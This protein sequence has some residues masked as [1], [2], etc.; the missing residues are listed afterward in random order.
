MRPDDG[1]FSVSVQHELL[2]RVSVDVSYNRRWFENFFVDDNQLVGP[3]GLQPVDV[4]GT[5]DARLPGGGGYQITTYSITREAA[6]RGA[7][8]YRTFE[9][10]SGTSGRRTGTA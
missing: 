10:I 6:L 8:T 4:H 5:A 2:P 9:R 1:Q 7:R 3:G